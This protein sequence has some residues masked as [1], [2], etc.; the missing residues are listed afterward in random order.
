MLDSSNPSVARDAPI[1]ISSPSSCRALRDFV[2]SS[3]KLTASSPGPPCLGASEVSPDLTT[4]FN[5]TIGQFVALDDPQFQ[6]IGQ[7]AALDYRRGKRGRGPTSGMTERSKIL[8]REARVHV[9][10][11]PAG[12]R[13]RGRLRSGSARRGA[14][15]RSRAGSDVE[16]DP[17]ASP[18]YSRATRRTSSGVTA[19]ILA[20]TDRYARGSPSVAAIVVEHAGL[21]GHRLEL[22]DLLIVPAR[23]GPCVLRRLLGPPS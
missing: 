16:P 5:V 11:S 13:S 8:Q 9:K 21:A 19:K 6:A 3:S 7:S 20:S 12:A 2:P 18:R 4:S 10:G 1:S 14:R 15:G 22:H 23:S 17:P